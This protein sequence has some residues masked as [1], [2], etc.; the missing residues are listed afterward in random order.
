MQHRLIASGKPDYFNSAEHDATLTNVAAGRG[1]CL[2]PGFLK[3]HS[4]QFAWIPFDCKESFSCVLC[5]HKE[6][7]RESL[8]AFRDLLRGRYREA[9][10][11][12]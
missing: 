12:P 1:V 3:D 7:R 4:G 6:D 10:F 11:P 2:T 8:P 5:T 9:A